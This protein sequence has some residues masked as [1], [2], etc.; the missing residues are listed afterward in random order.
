MYENIIAVSID[1]N[2]QNLM[3]LEAFADQ[4]HLKVKNFIDPV[5][6]LE[7]ITNNDVDIIFTDYMMPE[8]NGLELI[9]QFRKTNLST[10][11]IMVTAAGEKSRS[12]ALSAGATDFLNKPLDLSDFIVRTKNL[13]ALRD[14]QIQLSNRAKQ[15]EIEVEKATQDLIHR[16]HESL[17]VLGKTAEFKDPETA[18]HIARVAHYSKL[19]ASKYGLDEEQQD[20]VFYS[21]PFHDIGKVGIKDNILLKPGKLTDEEFDI[22]KTHSAIGF[23]ILKDTQSKYLKMGATIAISHHEKFNGKGYPHKLKGTDIP[24]EGRIVAIADVFDA[25]VSQRPY[26]KPWTFDDAVELLKKESGEHFDPK[27]VNI[28]VDNINSIKEIYNNFQ[29]SF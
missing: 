25:L 9:A 2:E 3:L 22:M 5:K 19:L 7:F 6:A 12:E 14:A 1:D 29:E 10:P 11:I 17:I 16:E 18:N 23:E 8:L 24:I 20:I 28:F 26:K 13:L 21:S 27:L 4:I 15:L